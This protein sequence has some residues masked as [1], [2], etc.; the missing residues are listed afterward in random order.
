MIG[1]YLDKFDLMNHSKILER[2]Y[3]LF[4]TNYLK[5]GMVLKSKQNLKKYQIIGKEN[6]ILIL[7]DCSRTRYSKKYVDKKNVTTDF[8]LVKFLDKEKLQNR[9]LCMLISPSMLEPVE[10]KDKRIYEGFIN[11]YLI[12]DNDNL[13]EVLCRCIDGNTFEKTDNFILMDELDNLIELSFDEILKKYQ[14][15]DVEFKHMI[16]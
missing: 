14:I 10:N 15:V 1:E 5:K 3:N 2:E 12:D 7:D 6:N 8:T 9:Q 13:F 11:T 4:N 16:K